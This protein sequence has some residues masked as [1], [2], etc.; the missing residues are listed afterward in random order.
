MNKEILQ[1]I[2]VIFLV[3]ILCITV[4]STPRTSAQTNDGEN[5][6]DRTQTIDFG[7]SGSVGADYYK[8]AS[9]ISIDGNVDLSGGLELPV[10]VTTHPPNELSPGDE[11]SVETVV[12]RGVGHDS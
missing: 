5:S 12:E 6:N 10:E 2:L 1:K 9:V 8:S 3:S 11:L 7:R 4:L